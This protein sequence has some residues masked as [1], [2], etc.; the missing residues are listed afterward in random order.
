[1]L[2]KPALCFAEHVARLLSLCHF[3]QVSVRVSNTLEND[4][5]FSPLSLTELTIA[6]LKLEASARK[7]LHQGL[8]LSV[9]LL[10]LLL[11]LL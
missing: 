8:A 4:R 9:S 6:L 5:N 7:V 11:V 10:A 1:M 2:R 3:C